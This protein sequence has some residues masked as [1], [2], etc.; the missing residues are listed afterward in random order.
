[1]SKRSFDVRELASVSGTI[2]GPCPASEVKAR[3][4]LADAEAEVRR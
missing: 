2:F 4:A 3:L 1:M